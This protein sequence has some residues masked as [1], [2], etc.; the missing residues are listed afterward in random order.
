MQLDILK[1]GESEAEIMS[2]S[3]A[4]QYPLLGSNLEQLW[5][6]NAIEWQRYVRLIDNEMKDVILVPEEKVED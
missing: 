3:I 6:E 2:R 5:K 4:K 1:P